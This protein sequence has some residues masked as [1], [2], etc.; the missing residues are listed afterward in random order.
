MEDDCHGPWNAISKLPNEM[1]KFIP[2]DFEELLP[3][4]PLSSTV[5]EKPF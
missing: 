3:T 1:G 4:T 2:S 5:R